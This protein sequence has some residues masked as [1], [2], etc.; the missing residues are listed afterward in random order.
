M[1]EAAVKSMKTHLI[2]IT[3]VKFI[4]KESS[5]VLTQ[6]EACLHNTP[7]VPLE[8][9]DDDGIQALTPSYFLIGQ[10]LMALP[11]PLHFYLYCC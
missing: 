6:I 11:D 10:P 5:T 8:I 2:R 3:N 7:L 1:L 4:Y 9:A